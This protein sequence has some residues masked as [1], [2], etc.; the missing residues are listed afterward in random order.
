MLRFALPL[1]AIALLA[2]PALAQEGSYVGSGEGELTAEI[3]HIENDV[4]AVSLGT[5]VAMTEDG[6]PGCGGGI[7]GEAILDETGGNFFVE[8]ED[9]DP[10]SDSPMLG[11]QYCEIAL[12]FDEDGFLNIEEKSGCIAYHGASCGF[13]GQ[14]INTSAI[15]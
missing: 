1:F 13:T 7:E 15:N 4:Y 10:K 14:L 6:M 3:K 8:N 9:Y 12:N 5:V 11:E 2:S